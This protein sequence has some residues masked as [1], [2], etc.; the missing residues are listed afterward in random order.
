L[1]NDL[2]KLKHNYGSCHNCKIA[3]WGRPSKEE[4]FPDG[5]VICSVCQT[6][7]TIEE[8]KTTLRRSKNA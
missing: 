8:I 5:I 7:E 6:I 4:K 2:D 1:T 3:M